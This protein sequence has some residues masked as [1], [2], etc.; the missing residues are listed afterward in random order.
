MKC[1]S[2]GISLALKIIMGSTQETNQQNISQVY[3]FLRYSS[4][5]WANFCR[6]YTLHKSNALPWKRHVCFFCLLCISFLLSYQ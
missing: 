5:Y 2:Y 1:G 6:N 4:I 3:V